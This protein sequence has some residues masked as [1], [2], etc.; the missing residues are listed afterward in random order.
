MTPAQF[1]A[2]WQNN[3]LTE[4]AGAQ[5]H[6]DDLCELLGV[7]KPRDSGHFGDL[8]ETLR[9][10]GL[11]SQPVAHFLIQCPSCMFAEDEGMLP[12]GIFTGLLAKS[13]S[14]QPTYWASSSMP[15]PPNLARVT[16]QTAWSP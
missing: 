16:A 4:R 5:G 7:D 15:T 12:R 9:G 8:A 13:K 3:P 2:L 10:R 11:D 1:V 14:R 6:F